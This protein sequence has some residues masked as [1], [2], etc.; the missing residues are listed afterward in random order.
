MSN[1]TQEEIK[2]QPLANDPPN[3]KTLK[4]G[5]IKWVMLMLLCLSQIGG[6]ISTNS[7]AY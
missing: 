5:N 3:I 7:P 4:S 6:F 1:K 2:I